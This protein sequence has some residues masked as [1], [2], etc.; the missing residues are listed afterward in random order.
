MAG[1][2]Q[3]N[4]AQPCGHWRNLPRGLRPHDPRDS[5]QLG[6]LLAPAGDVHM[7]VADYARFLPAHL[8]GLRGRVG[9][10][11]AATVKRLHLP[12][13]EGRERRV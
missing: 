13:W 6:A 3:P 1:R 4:P 5:Y 10:L 12:N 2:R 8:R 7:S 11:E 9:L